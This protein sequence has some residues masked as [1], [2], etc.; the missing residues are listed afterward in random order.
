MVQQK[1]VRVYRRLQR[2]EK[3]R[4]RGSERQQG[5]RAG[6]GVLGGETGPMMLLNGD[7]H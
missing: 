2:G 3:T 4:E 5:E 6:A 1:Q 7:G